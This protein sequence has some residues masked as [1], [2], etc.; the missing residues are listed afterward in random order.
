MGLGQLGKSSAV[1]C[2][3]VSLTHH[4]FIAILLVVLGITVEDALDEFASLSEKILG[5]RGLDSGART[6]ELKDHINT[7]LEKYG[8]KPE[9][10]LLD[11]NQR[12]KNCKLSVLFLVYLMSV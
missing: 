4:R 3:S 10:C 6:T 1:V 5:K 11:K 9:T 7:L 8:F 12:S 2:Q